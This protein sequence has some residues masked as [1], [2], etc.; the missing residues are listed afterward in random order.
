[1]IDARVDAT[2]RHTFF[3]NGGGVGIGNTNPSVNKLQVNGQVRVVGAQMIG[4]STA[5]NVVTAGVQLHLKNSGEAKIRL[6]D[7]DSSNLAFDILVNEGAGFSIK[8]T[9]G[10]DPGDDTRLFIEE[11]TGDVGLG[12]TTP[13]AKLD[14]AGGVRA[15]KGFSNDTDGLKLSYPGGGSNVALGNSGT[16]GS[17]KITLPVSW[18]NTM[19]RMTI[20]VYE[21][22]TNESFTLVCGGYN[23]GTGSGWLNEFAYIESQAGLDRNFTVRM[24]H[25][26]TNCCI[27]IGEL[28]SVWQYPKV[29]VTDFE[30]GF[31]NATASTWQ[32][33]WNISME[34]SAFG[35]ITYTNSGTQVNNWQRNGQDV[36]YGSGSGNVGIGTA[37]PAAL[38]HLNGTGD[39][40]R[41]TSTNA[42]VGGA[43]M[44]LLHFSASPSDGDI[45][46][47]INMGGYYSGTS[48]A[49][50][51]SIRTV[52]TDVS[53]R[54]GE[55]QFWTNSSGTFAQ[56]MVID[57]DG[58]VGIGDTT[59]S[60]KLDVNGTIRATGDV[61]A[62]SD[63][64]VKD[65]VETIEN[66]LDK[67]TKL[68]GVSYTRNDVEDKTT[69]IG[70]I[71][72]EVLEVLPE[73]VQQDDE[74]KY[75]VA[76]G[77]MVGLLIEAIKELKAEVDELKSR[78]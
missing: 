51:S 73:V 41:V 6:E 34:T 56:K 7:S 25:D 47:Y 77:N 9:V 36:Y 35:T 18:S 49:Y 60:Y 66:A 67:V 39:A 28:A 53:N 44:D 42:G 78:L 5:S 59:P 61:I 2:T 1:M 70:V 71:A 29:F 20:K 45:M 27:Y 16:V 38:L 54:D 24:G 40:I 48:S 4:D 22:T 37:S 75:S 26:G 17:I 69:K 14:V 68:R 55:L 57:K 72:Q 63:A 33:G 32:D 13:G 31:S 23:Y 21:Y 76:Y 50:F 43:Q 65:N 64:R 52:A 58:N 8:E 30:A 46:G 74:G 11:T 19:M 10:G 3:N 15:N 62:Y 12:T